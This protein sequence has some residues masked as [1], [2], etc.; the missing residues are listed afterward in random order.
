MVFRHFSIFQV[1]AES[2]NL[3]W[4]ALSF[5]QNGFL[6]QKN[7]ELSAHSVLCVYVSVCHT[8]SLNCFIPSSINGDIS[9]RPA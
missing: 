5:F 4:Q 8:N 3:I 9:E 1:D 6:F 7:W 2:K